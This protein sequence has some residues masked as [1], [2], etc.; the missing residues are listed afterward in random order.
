MIFASK[1]VCIVESFYDIVQTVL[2][3]EVQCDDKL[4][5]TAVGKTFVA[6][7]MPYIAPEVTIIN[8]VMFRELLSL[9]MISK[10]N[11]LM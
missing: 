8:K 5:N 11:E 7:L 2:E 6:A 4:H 10:Y 1:L 9:L 3:N